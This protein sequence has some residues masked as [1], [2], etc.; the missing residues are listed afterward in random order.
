V[1]LVLFV[2]KN[3]LSPKIFY[4]ILNNIFGLFHMFSQFYAKKTDCIYSVMLQY[5][6]FSFHEYKNMTFSPAAAGSTDIF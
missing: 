1:L 3:L 6:Y 4:K 5:L 2:L